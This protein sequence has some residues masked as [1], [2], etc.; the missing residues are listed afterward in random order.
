[1]ISLN[2]KYTAVYGTFIL[3][4]AGAMIFIMAKPLEKP[5]MVTAPYGAYPV[6]PSPEAALD[7]TMVTAS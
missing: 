4:S 5:D 1:M 3:L 2:K 6:Y 7:H